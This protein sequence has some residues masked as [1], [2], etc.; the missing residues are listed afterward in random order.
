MSEIEDK[1]TKTT[2]QY[3][4]EGAVIA[5]LYVV[6]SLLTYQFSY[7][8][9]QCR[10]AEALCMTIFFTPAGAWG[11]CIGCFITN[12]FGGSWLDT[13]CGTLATLIAVLL[14]TPIV[15]AIKRKTGDELGFLHSLLIPIPTVIVNAVIIPFVLYYGYGIETMGSAT[16]KTAVLALMSLSVG[17]G[18]I[19]SCYVFG[20][21][22]VKVM[23]AVEKHMNRSI[24][25]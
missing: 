8:E 18:E 16:A 9:I 11:V 25:Y 10:V 2:A 22:I 7:L 23:K 14:T 19:I 6:L 5:G 12:M 24:T 21:V 4:T 13:V 20:P 1:N 17:L 3:I 15:K